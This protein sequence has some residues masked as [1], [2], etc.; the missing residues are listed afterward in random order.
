MVAIC[1]K[2]W[3]SAECTEFPCMLR[4]VF[5]KNDTPS[6]HCRSKCAIKFEVV[7]VLNPA[8]YVI[9]ILSHKIGT[10]WS[11]LEETIRQTEALLSNELQE[12][13]TRRENLK[14]VD[15]KTTGSYVALIEKTWK[16]CKAIMNAE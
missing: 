5:G 8:H 15:I 3:M 4:H 14:K 12:F 7:N 1:D 11:S 9:K 6:E 10:N 16:R 13:C 2:I